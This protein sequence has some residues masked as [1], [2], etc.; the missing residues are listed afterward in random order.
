MECRYCLAPQS[1]CCF[2]CP[3][4]ERHQA[5]NA[6]TCTMFGMSLAALDSSRVHVQDQ[7]LAG[8]SSFGMSGVNAHAI[9]D[10]PQ[11]SP[12]DRAQLLMMLLAP[13][14]LPLHLMQSTCAGPAPGRHQLLWH[15]RRERARHPR[16]ATE[17]PCRPCPSA[18]Q[19]CLGQRACVASPA[20]HGAACQLLSRQWSCHICAR[21]G[22]PS[23]GLPARPPG[24]QL[25]E[26]RTWWT[27]LLPAAR[28]A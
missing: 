8:T 15:E 10:E 14:W 13:I 28:G 23:H 12:A 16:G 25:S 7:S 20:T 3:L 24:K 22:C 9:L 4:H 27:S 26:S 1:S 5:P 21:P 6:L 11:S 2:S 17:Q 18:P 19:P